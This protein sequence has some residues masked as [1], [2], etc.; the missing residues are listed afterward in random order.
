MDLDQETEEFIRILERTIPKMIDIETHTQNPVWTIRADHV[1]LEQVLL[2]LGNNAAS[3]LSPL[4][5]PYPAETSMRHWEMVDT[6]SR[7]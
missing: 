1:Q 2:N 5:L 7:L 6:F 4:P 3:I